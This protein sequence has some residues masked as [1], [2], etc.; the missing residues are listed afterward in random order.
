MIVHGIGQPEGQTNIIFGVVVIA[1]FVVI[2]PLMIYVKAKKQAIE[3]PVYKNPTYYTLQDDGIFVELGEESATIEWIRV[4]KITHFMGLT[5]LYTGKQ[6]AFVFPDY[7]LG[8]DREK[9]LD[10]MKEHIKEARKKAAQTQAD[11]G[12]ISKYSQ[13][14]VETEQSETEAETQVEASESE[15]Q[16]NSEGEK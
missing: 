15:V 1:L 2:N 10:Y 4:Y 14:S 13:A 8:D 12:D 3:N 7:E 6:Q 11:G 5:L 16:E 9:M